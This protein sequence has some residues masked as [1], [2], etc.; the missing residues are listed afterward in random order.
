L[1]GLVVPGQG[2][3]GWVAFELAPYQGVLA[4]G[5]TRTHVL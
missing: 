5:L 1:N 2:V 3:R 4:D